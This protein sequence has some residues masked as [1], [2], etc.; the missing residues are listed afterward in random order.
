MCCLRF[1]NG[2]NSELKKRGKN[3]LI[4]KLY[5]YPKKFIQWIIVSIGAKFYLFNIH[6][7]SIRVVRKYKSHRVQW[8]DHTYRLIRPVN[9]WLY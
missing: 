2:V 8:D 5:L 1:G 6:M 7:E 4:V 9:G 3:N